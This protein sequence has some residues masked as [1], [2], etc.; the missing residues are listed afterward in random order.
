MSGQD[1]G[2]TEQTCFASCCSSMFRLG[3]HLRLKCPGVIIFYPTGPVSKKIMREQK[4]FHFSATMLPCY[5][6]ISI[7]GRR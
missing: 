6:N 4:T 7:D 3:I 5:T 2:G 1:S